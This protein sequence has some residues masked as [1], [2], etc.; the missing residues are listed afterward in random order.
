MTSTNINIFDIDKVLFEYI[1]KWNG[2][3]DLSKKYLTNNEAKDKKNWLETS[4][5]IQISNMIN[6]MGIYRKILVDYITKHTINHIINKKDYSNFLHA[7][8]NKKATLEN[9]TLI[10][11]FGSNNPTS[12][13]DVTFAGA[14][15]HIIVKNILNKFNSKIGNKHNTTMALFFDSNF[16]LAPDLII[17]DYNRNIFIKNNIK[18]IEINKDTNHFLPIPDEKVIPFEFEY[19]LKKINYKTHETKDIINMKYNNLMIEAKKLDDLL[20]K[21]R[22]ING[23]DTFTSISFGNNINP[24]LDFFIHIM[25]MFEMSMEAYYCLS[26]I[27]AV[28]YSIQ[29]KKKIDSHMKSYN[30]LIASLEN[31]IDLVKHQ[32]EACV[33]SKNNTPLQMQNLAIKLSKYIFRIYYCLNKYYN[34][35]DNKNS[36]KP[37]DFNENY[38]L[39]TNVFNARGATNIDR[40]QIV[41]YMK[42][43]GLNKNLKNVKNN[44]FVKLFDELSQKS[45]YKQEINDILFELF[46]K[47]KKQGSKNSIKNIKKTS[48]YN[49]SQTLK[50]NTR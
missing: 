39:A 33:K 16:Y 26:T 1:Y 21:N 50:N 19:L 11:A 12:D 42:T 29:A 7:F 46:M 13:Y 5:P 20:Y 40:K 30:W 45:I 27:L 44:M 6:F 10:N 18:L 23:E 4:I 41:I 25:N 37:N 2:W 15:T 48:N 9:T 8:K 17:N 38:N 36:K 28:V 49:K 14:G 35:K 31:M 32:N 47:N 22:I 3:Q 24:K 34:C 43:F